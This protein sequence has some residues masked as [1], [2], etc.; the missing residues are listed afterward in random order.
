LIAGGG[1]NVGFDTAAYSTNVWPAAGTVDRKG[2]KDR[3]ERKGRNGNFQPL[4][5]CPLIE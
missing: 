2:R 5:A 4:G 1:P 3:K